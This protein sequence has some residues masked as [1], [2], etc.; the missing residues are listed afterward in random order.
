M[1]DIL[2][3]LGGL[4]LGLG[5]SMTAALVIGI[6]E[7]LRWMRDVA[8]AAE[9]NMPDDD[10][11][12]R[13]FRR[14]YEKLDAET[15]EPHAELEKLEHRYIARVR[16]A[17]LEVLRERE[18]AEGSAVPHGHD[19]HGDDE[20]NNEAA[21]LQKLE[22]ELRKTA[23]NEV[24]EAR[25]AAQLRFEVMDQLE[26]AVY[27]SLH[28][29]FRK[30]MSEYE[31]KLGFDDEERMLACLRNDTAFQAGT[32]IISL[33]A[34]VLAGYYT[35]YWADFSPYL[36]ASIMGAL[37]AAIT[38]LFDWRKY[39]PAWVMWTWVLLAIPASLAGAWIFAG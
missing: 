24:L 38:F 7:G 39:G 32:L 31:E 12:S 13:T 37:A 26:S 30:S 4:A 23:D 15:G 11:F 36:H 8:K 21:C 14:A 6:F 20:K 28:A 34:Q 19:G 5:I 29:R 22:K 9:A 10:C 1:P 17:M 25:L 3:I 2:A 18:S 33:L 27:D 16:Q 35:A